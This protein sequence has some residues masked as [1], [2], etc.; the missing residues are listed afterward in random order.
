MIINTKKI[1]LQAQKGKYAIPAFNIHNLEDMRACVEAAYELSSPII[2]AA[3]PG[4]F[5]FSGLKNIIAIA[6]SLSEMYPIPIALHMDHHHDFAT[7]KA[8]IDNGI[9]S[10]MIDASSLSLKEN[11]TLTK[12]IMTYAIKF[13]VSVEAELG[14]IGGVEDDLVVDQKD[15]EY[16][17]PS[18]VKKFVEETNVNSIAVAIGTAHGIYHTPPIL[19]IE[20]LKKIKVICSTPLVL[21]GGSGLSKNQIQSCIANG[22]AKVNIGTELKAPFATSIYKSLYQDI[23]KNDPRQYL[24]QAVIDLKKLVKTKIAICKSINKI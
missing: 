9:K 22:C 14:K 3:T 4:T 7:I 12:K 11:I 18:V 19:N 1:I 2:L 17:S 10:V 23:T 6:N 24:K 16:T 13:D 15:I 20:L 5:S 21:H 8:G